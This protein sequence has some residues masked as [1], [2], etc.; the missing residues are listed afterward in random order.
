M[1]YDKD[2]GF[3]LWQLAKD[4]SGAVERVSAI[5]AVQREHSR[6]ISAG[7]RTCDELR[8][9]IKHMN[10]NWR[11]YIYGAPGI[12]SQADIATRLKR[13]ETVMWGVA[14]AVVTQAVGGCVSF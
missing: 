9:N 6:S 5:E 11:P 2:D 1:G 14:V 10:K 8:E 7:R 3:A 12:P 4:L 13:I